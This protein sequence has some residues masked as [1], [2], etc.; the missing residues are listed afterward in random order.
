MYKKTSVKYQKQF[1][2]GNHSLNIDYA[3]TESNLPTSFVE[4]FDI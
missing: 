4:W 1:A 3:R 2:F